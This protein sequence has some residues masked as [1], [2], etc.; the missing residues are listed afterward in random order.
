MLTPFLNGN[1]VSNLASG[2]KSYQ[3]FTVKLFPGWNS[4][5][6]ISRFINRLCYENMALSFSLTWIHNERERD[7]IRGTWFT[8]LINCLYLTFNKFIITVICPFLGTKPW[9]LIW[10]QKEN[11]WELLFCSLCLTTRARPQTTLSSLYFPKNWLEKII[12]HPLL[13]PRTYSLRLLSYLFVPFFIIFG[14]L[15]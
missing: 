8:F 3:G 13:P 4:L 15:Y 6:L 14:H 2:N 7:T 12:T 1:S 11:T 5:V 10:E 9:F